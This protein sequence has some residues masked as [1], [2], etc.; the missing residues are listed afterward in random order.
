MTSS[1]RSPERGRPAATPG[2]TPAARRRRRPTRAAHGSRG[3]IADLR[4]AIA[5]AA[6]L[7]YIGYGGLRTLPADA[8]GAISWR[9]LTQK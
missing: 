3:L 8:I 5:A 9:Y 7:R 6:V 4:A 1:T 2:T